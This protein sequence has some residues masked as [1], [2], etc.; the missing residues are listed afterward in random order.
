ML[1][2]DLSPILS[3]LTEFAKAQPNRTEL[4]VLIKQLCL[5][6]K[7][8]DRLPELQ[9]L[10]VAALIDE[11]IETREKQTTQFL[12]DEQQSGR[13]IYGEPLTLQQQSEIMNKLAEI[14]DD[15]SRLK[16]KIA[17]LIS[18]EKSHPS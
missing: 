1:T 2:F 6:L 17:S 5:Y 11:L 8:F 12:R 16:T 18:A 15:R 13:T 14:E 7:Y 9:T 3:D 4:S 10:D